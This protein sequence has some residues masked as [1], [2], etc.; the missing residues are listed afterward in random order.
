MIDPRFAF[1]PLPFSGASGQ[2]I[3]AVSG[4]LALLQSQVPVPGRPVTALPFSEPDRRA[5]EAFLRDVTAGPM[6]KLLDYFEGA[7][8]QRPELAACYQPLHQ[9]VQAFRNRDYAQALDLVYRTYRSIEMLRAQ[10]PDLPEVGP[11]IGDA[12]IRRQPA[13]A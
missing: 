3:A 4:L 8:S 1:S 7:G 12:T 9:A 13:Q 5:A 10:Y 2:T 6:R 11:A